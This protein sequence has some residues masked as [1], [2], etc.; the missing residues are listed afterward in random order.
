[1]TT[2]ARLK[3][4]VSPVALL[5]VS[6][7]AAAPL[8]AQEL[9]LKR[10]HSGVANYECPRVPRGP[11]PSLEQRTRAMELASSAATSVVLGDDERARDLLIWA[12]ALDPTSAD[13][14]YRL[15]RA[16]DDLD[17]RTRALAEYCR[18]V[19]V[20]GTSE[21]AKFSRDR[22]AVLIDLEA[23]SIPETA[24]TAFEL[25]VS[26]FDRGRLTDARRSFAIAASVAPAWPL[27]H[28]NQGVTLAALGSRDEAVVSLR[29]YIERDPGA[30][31]V[32]VVSEQIGQ[33]RGAPALGGLSPYTAFAVGVI[34]PGLGQY[35]SGRPLRGAVVTGLAAGALATGF[36]VKKRAVRCLVVLTSDGSCPTGE[37]AS[38]DVSRPYATTG[39]A[40]AL[41]VSVLGAL[42]AYFG[43]RARSRDRTFA[44]AGGLR[45]GRPSISSKDG[46]VELS[47]LSLRMR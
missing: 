33:L 29:R 36:F 41:G 34:V 22:I 30:E 1:M 42:D 31:D 24:R 45:I 47:V 19:S 37:I 10:P 26:A 14:R 15:A 3:S 8:G 4:E 16:L 38:V 6:A 32:L 23:A 18:T 40:V 5:C 43:A 28:Y 17:E 13:L 44:Q 7:M 11:E 21:E 20:G 12:T 25:G 2:L 46:A 27:A 9:T 35:S 39:I